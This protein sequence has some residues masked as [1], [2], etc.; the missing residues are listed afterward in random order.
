[1]E[2][3]FD[4][5]MDIGEQ[6]LTSGAE[7]HRVEESIQRMCL[8]FGA[9]R[10]DAFVIITSMVVTIYMD[11]G[12]SCTQTRRITSVDADASLQPGDILL[13]FAG[14]RVGDL[15]GLQ[16][17]LRGHHPGDTVTLTVYREGTQLE[18]QLTLKESE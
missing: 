11:H 1:M 18:L 8:A 13:R 17:L 16:Q 5:A 14:Q 15:D 9:A 12:E 3:M 2:K 10:V 6:M 7:V 4:C